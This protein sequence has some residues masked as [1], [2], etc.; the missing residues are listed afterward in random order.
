MEEPISIEPD[1]TV[2]TG[3]D[4]ARVYADM[5]KVNAEVGRLIEKRDEARESALAKLAAL[6]LDES[7][8]QALLG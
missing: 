5:K 2:W 4:D 7:E 6:G 8:I 1:G 3:A